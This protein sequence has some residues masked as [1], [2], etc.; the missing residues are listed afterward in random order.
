[1][2]NDQLEMQLFVRRCLAEPV[3]AQQLGQRAQELVQRHVGATRRTLEM[4]EA[5][6]F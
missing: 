3:F 5:L 6:V 4:L 1:V 2:V